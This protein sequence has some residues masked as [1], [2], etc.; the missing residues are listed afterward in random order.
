MSFWIS[1]NSNDA[2]SSLQENSKKPYTKIDLIGKLHII[3]ALDNG[4]PKADIARDYGVHPQTITYIYKQKE[5]LIRKY[6]Q[7]YNLLKEVRCINLN[8]TLLDWVASELKSGKI[9]KE[10][11]LRVKAEEIINTMSEDFNCVDDWL[12]DF[13]RRN[14]ILKFTS[15]IVCS[16][17]AKDEWHTFVNDLDASNLYIG[18]VFGLYHS[19]D[20]DKYISKQKAD[21]H[22]YVF[23]I[24]NCLGADK[25]ELVVIGDELLECSNIK[26]LPVQYIYS[27]NLNLSN[28]IIRNCL[29]K[30]NNDLKTQNRKVSLVMDVSEKLLN[31]ISYENIEIKRLIN[32]EFITKN[33]QMIEKCFKFHYRRIQMTKKILYN[34][35]SSVLSSVDYTH[36]I[37]VAWHSVSNEY[38]QRL[39]FP[40]ENDSLYFNSCDANDSNQSL[41]QWCKLHNIPC[42]LVMYSDDLDNFIQCDKNLPIMCT[43]VTNDLNLNVNDT[44]LGN[45]VVPSSGVQ[46]YQAIKRLITYLQSQNAKKSV[47]NSAKILEDHL[48][49]GALQEIQQV[50][51]TNNIPE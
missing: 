24:V 40:L 1:K 50:M 29:N 26:S 42:D 8:Q 13:R 35:D 18:G 5:A 20:F 48:E 33:I 36:I 27:Q 30:W 21:K 23:F 39:F 38:I 2:E 43:N 47:V 49:Y 46:A 10:V 25:K 45:D 4:Q 14:N 9:I 37:S 34:K 15:E 12:L 16:D 22:V 44:L 17:V 41:L 28:I 11:Q 51:A 32:M 6:S 19:L 7:K 31:D 3:H